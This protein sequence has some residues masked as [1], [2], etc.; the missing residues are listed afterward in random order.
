MSNWQFIYFM[1][2]AWAANSVEAIDSVV[3]MSRVTDN[4]VVSMQLSVI[5]R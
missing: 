2:L 5:S 4:R 1:H 3:S